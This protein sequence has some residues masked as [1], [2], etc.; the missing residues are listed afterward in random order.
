[1]KLI[2]GLGN[3]GTQYDRTRHNVGF[4]ALDAFAQK[5]GAAN[6]RVAHESLQ[7]IVKHANARRASVAV[8]MQKGTVRMTIKDNGKGFDPDEAGGRGGLGLIGM[9]ERARLVNGSLTI[10]SRPGRG[11]RIVLAV[12]V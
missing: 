11:T 12:P 8:S 9:Q 7:N 6:Y 4:L 1:M 3:P 5:H 2:V 10:A